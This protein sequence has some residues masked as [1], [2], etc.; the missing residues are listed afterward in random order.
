MKTIIRIPQKL[1]DELWW[2]IISVD[3]DYSRICIADHDITEEHI[4]IW[5]ED[6]HN[7]KNTLDECLLLNISLKQFARFIKAEG[8]NSYEST[9]MHPK[10]KFLYKTRTVIN[11]AI[12]WYANDATPVEQGWTRDALLKQLLTQLVENEL[13]SSHT[14]AN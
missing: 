8:F 9:A 7:F 2:L 6:K 10:K 4:S 3:F 13:F 1:R 5:L 14:Y 12:S 11:E